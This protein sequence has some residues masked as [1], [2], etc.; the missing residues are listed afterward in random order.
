MDKR[1]RVI[2]HMIT[3]IDGKIVIDWEG[4]ADYAFAGQTYEDMLS[5]CAAW[6]CGR[7][8]FQG[9]LSSSRSVDLACY[10]PA[11][12]P[13]ADRIVP[14]NG[15]PLCVAIDRF[16]K[17]RWE[18]SSMPYAGLDSLILE[19]LTEQAD[20]RYLT[21]LDSLGTPYLFAGKEDFDPLLFLEKLKRDYQVDTF[22]LCGGAEINAVFME[23]DLVDE[24]SLVI[25]PAV[26]GARDCLTFVG[27]DRPKGF[28]KYFRLT[29]LKDLGH[30]TVF[31][32]Y[33]R[34]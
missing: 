10:S 18:S 34:K 9:N 32:R 1:A 20:P 6:G 17:L 12:P 19:V 28:P 33:E 26:D 30:S 29:E 15:R 11:E 21:Y 3:T 22:C 24:I 2:C 27:T 5:G 31:L 8:T 23:Q 7:E 13:L 14:P 16:G 4:D 25:G